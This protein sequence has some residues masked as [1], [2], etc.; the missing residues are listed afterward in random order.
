MEQITWEFPLTRTHTGILMGNGRMGGI[1][2][3][4]GNL[5]SVTVG[6]ADFWDHRGGMPFTEK[7]NMRNISDILLRKD[8]EAMTALFETET[9]GIPGQPRNPSILPVGRLELDFGE[10]ALLKT[11][12]LEIR[13]GRVKIAYRKHGVDLSVTFVISMES[14]TLLVVPDSAD[15]FPAVKAVPAWNQVGDI[16]RKL[17]FAPPTEFVEKNGSVFGFV[18]TCPAD[19][20]L[21]LACRIGEGHLVAATGRGPGADEA[22]TEA[23]AAA[24]AGWRGTPLNFIEKNAAWWARFWEDVPELHLPDPEI[25]EIFLYDMYKFAGM[26]NPDGVPA[27][28]QGPWIEDYRLPPW[29]A[30][31]HFN[32]NA[33]MN[34]WP[35]YK[36]NRLAH[37]KRLLEMIW[38]CREVFR[39]DAKMLVGIDDGYLL[40]HSVDDR[41][42]CMGRY[43][44]GN[45]D[46][47]CAGWIARMMFEYYLYSGDLEFLENI[48]FPFMKGTM[49]VYEKLLVRENGVYFMPIGV[50]AEWNANY[51]EPPSWGRNPSFQLACI[52]RLCEDLQKAG[53]LLNCPSEPFWQDIREH[54]PQ[55]A[56]GDDYGR[57]MIFVWE[58]QKPD[59]SHRH[60]SHLAAIYPFE[61]VDLFSDEWHE[62]IQYSIAYWTG[63]GSGGWAGWS[64]PW[65]AII[66]TRYGCGDAAE[67]LLKVWKRF[68]TNEGRGTLHDCRFNGVS[69]PVFSAIA[70]SC[71]KAPEVGIRKKTR[72]S[73]AANPP[74]Y[75]IMQIEAG[76]GAAAAVMEML[77]HSRR[78]VV[79][80][81]PAVPEHWKTV[82]FKGMLSEGG[83]LISAEQKNSETEWIEV[84][85]TR[86]GKLHLANPWSDEAV[87]RKRDGEVRFTGDILEIPL[88]QGD[89]VQIFSC[90]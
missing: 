58:G 57:Q 62:L 16:L 41:G 32:I 42:T 15:V 29:S 50:S 36:G 54:L 1:L 61:T 63:K 11:G 52:H 20:A 24:E 23:K 86:D 68:F 40:P 47:S 14:D 28:L 49:R 9:F 79:H 44:S 5:L 43:W 35:A 19:A 74:E 69:N 78:G 2:W 27:G 90:E 65:A 88:K 59:C 56:A 85:A 12:T 3:G 51:V 21:C 17:S 34:Y 37:V 45:V 26:T 77:M 22:K 55:F 38:E 46:P 73:F 64:F 87:C 33:Q 30:D 13:T 25:E 48:A 70:M 89:F 80:V 7:H 18:Q 39:H 6:R 75:E 10:G 67:M 60:F 71:G 76:M 81:F 82:S 8:K 84:T 72:R 4:A 83:F 31:Y 53:H 66:N